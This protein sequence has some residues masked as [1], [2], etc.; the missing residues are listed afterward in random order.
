[1]LASLCHIIMEHRYHDLSKGVSIQTRECPS[2]WYKDQTGFIKSKYSYFIIYCLF[3]IIYPSS[4][5]VPEWP[6]MLRRLLITLNGTICGSLQFFSLQH[7]I[8]QEALCFLIWPLNHLLQLFIVVRTCLVF[9]KTTQ[10][11]YSLFLI[12]T[13]HWLLLFCC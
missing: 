11:C 12:P 13:L 4:E 3:S 9:G 7:F 6:L 10:T 1:M 8:L 5:N 2:W